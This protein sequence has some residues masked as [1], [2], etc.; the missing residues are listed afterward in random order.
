MP[1]L[2]RNTLTSTQLAQDG[3]SAGMSSRPED[4]SC[5]PAVCGAEALLLP[6]LTTSLTCSRV[7]ALHTC[8]VNYLQRHWPLEPQASAKS[9]GALMTPGAT[10]IV[11][12]RGGSPA[13]KADVSH[14]VNEFA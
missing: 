8:S 3:P 9:P 2:D 4:M 6:S 7:L 12:G 14:L 5:S 11:Q 10:H 1:G 13:T